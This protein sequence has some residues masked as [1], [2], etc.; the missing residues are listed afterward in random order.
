MMLKMH[1]ADKGMIGK[2]RSA[3]FA[4]GERCGNPVG[5]FV[6]HGPGLHRRNRDDKPNCKD[7]G[8]DPSAQH[9]PSTDHSIDTTP[10]VTEHACLYRPFWSEDPAAQ[11]I[12]GQNIGADAAWRDFAAKL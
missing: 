9:T 10:S 11:A 1:V 3:L 4:G 8:D 7:E 2:T 5:V 12:A 6:K